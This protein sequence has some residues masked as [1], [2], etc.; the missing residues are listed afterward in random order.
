VGKRKSMNSR[1]VRPVGIALLLCL[2]WVD[3]AFAAIPPQ[4]LATNFSTTM[5]G[6]ATAAA[7]GV[8]AV[9]AL[10][11]ASGYLSQNPKMVSNAYWGFLGAGVCAA[12]AVVFRIARGAIQAIAGG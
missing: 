6:V 12:F 1:W 5:T 4:Q 10:I 8:A 9:A 11:L 7:V 2:V 3:P